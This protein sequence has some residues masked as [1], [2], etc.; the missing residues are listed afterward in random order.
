MPCV[1]A[2]A[3]AGGVRWRWSGRHRL[4]RLHNRDLVEIHR[5]DWLILRVA[6]HLRNGFGDQ[7]AGR[8]ALPEDGVVLIE[9]RLWTDRDKK[10]G[11]VGIRTGI[12]HCQPA[13]HIEGQ[14]W[15]DLIVEKIAGIS[16]SR[17]RG[18]STLNHE[19]RNHS[20]KR[21]AV[22]ERLAMHLFVGDG[23]REFLACP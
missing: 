18:I 11:A 20:M 15:I 17:A 9:R 22:V 2:V 21:G 13:R 7:N 5:L 19:S 14:V 6:R 4:A 12:R 16:R 10:L 23:I 8:I 1:G 3:A